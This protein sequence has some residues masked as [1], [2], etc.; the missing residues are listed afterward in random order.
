MRLNSDELS[1]PQKNAQLDLS[2][3]GN[4]LSYYLM[5]YTII[6]KA[7]L[8]SWGCRS[9]E[10]DMYIFRKCFILDEN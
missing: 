5:Y 10:R 3:F 9:R 7:F 8:I 4:G 1:E 6:C 2:R